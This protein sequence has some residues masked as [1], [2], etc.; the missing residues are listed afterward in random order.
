MK[1]GYVRLDRARLGQVKLD[2][3]MLAQVGSGRFR[4]GLVRSD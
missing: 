4:S 3:I 2:E 1:L